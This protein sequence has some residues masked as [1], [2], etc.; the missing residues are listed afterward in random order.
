MTEGPAVTV[1]NADKVE[2]VTNTNLPP[3]STT[4]GYRREEFLSDLFVVT[5]R[6]QQAQST[7]S[8]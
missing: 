5:E 7:Q 6:D 2:I 1:S 8:S 4:N 3:E